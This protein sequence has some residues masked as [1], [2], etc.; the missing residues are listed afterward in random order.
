MGSSS[1]K[2]GEKQMS[3]VMTR[4]CAVCGKLIEFTYET[5]ARR[6]C[7][8]C[9]RARQLEA[10]KEKNRRFK[11]KQKELENAK[12]IAHQQDR[13]IWVTDYAER[14]KQRTLAMLGGIK[15]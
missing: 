7:P 2:G 9:K 8:E 10:S 12:R 6:Y 13:T 11:D 4:P 5:K 15:V 1:V 14:Q 3:E